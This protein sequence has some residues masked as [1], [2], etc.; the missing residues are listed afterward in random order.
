MHF[1]LSIKNITLRC[2]SNGKYH[3][4]ENLYSKTKKEN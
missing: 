3:N 1:V 2:I 4:T